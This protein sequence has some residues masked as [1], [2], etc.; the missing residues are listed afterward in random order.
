M[1]VLLSLVSKATLH[2]DATDITHINPLSKIHVLQF[3]A[4]SSF[5]VIKQEFFIW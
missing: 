1:F 2:V 5:E 4:S 3:S